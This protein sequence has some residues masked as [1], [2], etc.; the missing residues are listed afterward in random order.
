MNEDM[1][2]AMASQLRQPSCEYATEV[3]KMMN[4]GNLHIHVNTFESLDVSDGDHLLE[5]GMGNGYFVHHILSKANRIQ[6]VGCDF[7]EVMIEESRNQ[8]AN[9]IASGQAHFIFADAHELPFDNNIFDQIIIV[10]TMY[11]WD[12]PEKV[13]SEI[14]RVLKPQGQL[15]IS[16]RPKHTMEHYPF[17][18]YG[19]RTFSKDELVEIL[20]VN[21]FNVI[22]I[23]EKEEPD[24]D[25][26]GELLKAASLI[27]MAEKM[28]GIHGS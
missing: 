17:V 9:F 20:S 27:V 15:T 13:L 25:M 21:N 14:R 22:K 2:K 8:N 19:F 12:H 26:D 5:I 23:I 3:G 28:E 11:F 7:S 18:K 16:I 10:N 1:L 6:Y 24:I 4:E